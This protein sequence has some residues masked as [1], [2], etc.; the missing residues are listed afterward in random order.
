MGRSFNRTLKTYFTKF[1]RRENAEWKISRCV[2]QISRGLASGRQ[3]WRLKFAI[4][5]DCLFFW[6]II[7]LRHPTTDPW[8][9]VNDDPRCTGTWTMHNDQGDV[10]RSAD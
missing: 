2:Q 8:G 3:G 1:H 6:C 4:R 9:I 10:S 5:H 7:F